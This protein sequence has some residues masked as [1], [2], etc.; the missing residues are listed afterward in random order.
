VWRRDLL[1]EE[2][3][4]RGVFRH[5][6]RFHPAVVLQLPRHI[7]NLRTT[8]VE[9]FR[10]GLVF[11]AHRLLYHSTLGLDSNKEEEEGFDR[12]VLRHV[13]RL[14]AAVVLQLPVECCFLCARYPC[15][16]F[17]GP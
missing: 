8:N 2:G 17:V 6:E 16:T 10:G 9:R 3:F 12:G 14:H 13:E 7:L 11:K 5:V 1:G 15:G 4:D